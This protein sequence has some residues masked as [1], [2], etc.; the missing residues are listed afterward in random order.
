[1][2]MAWP[3]KN[4]GDVC[5]IIGGGTPSKSRQDFYSG[6]IPWATVRDMKA[7]LITST[8]CSI[9]SEAVK[10]SS[11]NVIPSG[12]VIIAT[13]VG[14]G[15]VCMLGQETAINQ[16]L[17]GVV[18]KSTKTLDVGFLFRWLKSVAATIVAEGT[19][20][21]VQGVKL[22]FV[23]SLQVPLPP[24]PEQKRI[25]AILDEAFAGIDSA[26]ANTEKNLT[27]A[28][29]LFESYL[30]G[31]FTQR[32][33]GWVEKPVIEIAKVTS[34]HSFKS[35]DFSDKS[36]AKSI[37]IT[38]VGVRKFVLEANNFL[39]EDFT[40]TY[41]RFQVAEGDIVI[42]LT[43][44]IISTG[45]KVAIV[46][47]EYDGAL[48]N[49][50]VAA[51]EVNSNIVLRQFLYSFLCTQ[52]VIGYVKKQANTLMQPNL[53][54]TDLK[55]LS[56]SVPPITEQKK[57]VEKI[58]A[59]SDEAQ[60]LESVYQQKLNALAELRQSILQ[61]AFAGELT[62]LPEETLEGAIA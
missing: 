28:R 59:L 17:R 4:L 2:S 6:S 42:A 1:M 38:N 29:E 41:N 45:L 21:T 36:G 62:S 57:L 22:P 8:E 55:N 23:K 12:N 3:T 50:R 5:N 52:S 43:R 53:S 13:R 34:G 18:P 32:G 31:V 10:G 54:I 33:D 49:Q 61:K 51:I 11:T 26:V 20:V 9:T 16:D 58:G 27:N 44:S 56:V 46:P 7:E 15:K 37:K 19:G 39:P 47:S 24:L 25:V 14:L 48:L 30:N 40:E 60:H 35:G